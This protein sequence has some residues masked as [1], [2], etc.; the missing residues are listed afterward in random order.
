MR[1]HQP[2]EADHDEDVGQR[3][4]DDVTEA[5]AVTTTVPDYTLHNAMIGYAVTRDLS[6]RLNLNNLTDE[7]YARFIHQ[8]NTQYYLGEPRSLE[9]AVQ[10]RY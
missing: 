3:A 7:V 6:L 4:A 10:W 9:V 8:T 1:H 5:A 2:D